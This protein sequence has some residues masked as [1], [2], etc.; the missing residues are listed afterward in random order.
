MHCRPSDNMK[1]QYKEEA[2]RL[3][4]YGY[5]KEYYADEK[6]SSSSG[7]YNDASS[8]ADYDYGYSKGGGGDIVHDVGKCWYTGVTDYGILYR[9]DKERPDNMG[10]L[11]TFTW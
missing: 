6:S 1:E 7:N 4:D 5:D 11:I 2:G 3:R 9:K 10:T 8:G